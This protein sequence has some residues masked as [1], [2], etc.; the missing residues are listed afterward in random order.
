M[1][2][3]ST[4]PGPARWS[5]TAFAP[6]AAAYFAS[7]FAASN[8]S[9]PAMSFIP[10]KNPLR[11]TLVRTAMDTLKIEFPESILIPTGQTR[12]GFLEEAKFLL[13]AKLFELGRLSSGRAA[14]VCGMDRVTFLLSLHRVGIAALD[15]DAHD[16]ADDVRYARGE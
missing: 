4:F 13:A 7:L 10:M 5:F 8:V 3:A 16:V 1:R 11:G 15:L 2:A 6:A 14:E 9:T 12:E